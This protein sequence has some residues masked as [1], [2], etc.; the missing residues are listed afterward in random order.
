MV[1]LINT[2]AAAAHYLG[3]ASTDAEI[4]WHICDA[5]AAAESVIGKMCDVTGVEQGGRA[6]GETLHCL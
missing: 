2:F 4:I 3:A 1:T 6:S 5:A